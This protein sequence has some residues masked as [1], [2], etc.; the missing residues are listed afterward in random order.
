MKAISLAVPAA[1]LRKNVFEL[2]VLCLTTLVLVVAAWIVVKV[3][4][5]KTLLRS[6]EIRVSRAATTLQGWTATFQPAANEESA[7]WR[8][9]SMEAR[10]LG[11]PHDERLVITAAI[12]RQAERPGFT[13]V[14]VAFATPDSVPTPPIP[15][16]AGPHVFAPASYR[17]SIN[18]RGDLGTTKRL[19]GNLPAA[20][21][22]TSMKFK[23]D[24]AALRGSIMLNIYEPAGGQ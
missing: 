22:V 15:R 14:R 18:F 6:E 4:R 24:G 20:A 23:R 17:V 19:L 2:Q 8:Q 10:Q 16:T 7:A 1:Y 21:L 3:S 11:T 5:Q 9:T 13:D 12:A